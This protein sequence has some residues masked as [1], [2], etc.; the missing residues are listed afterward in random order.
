MVEVLHCDPKFLFMTC[1]INTVEPEIEKDISSIGLI[2]NSVSFSKL[3]KSL[4]S[5]EVTELIKPF[6]KA[7]CFTEHRLT[8]DLCVTFSV[9]LLQVF[10]FVFFSFLLDKQHRGLVIQFWSIWKTPV[11]FC[12]CFR[13]LTPTSKSVE[14]TAMMCH[15]DKYDI[16]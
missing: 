10:N 12:A 15:S 9:K 3:L 11:L 5:M 13:K 6:F 2:K 8:T 16:S 14:F 4:G 7:L 1:D